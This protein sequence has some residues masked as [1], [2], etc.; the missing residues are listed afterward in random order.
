MA[1]LW[2][3]F[4]TS[5]LKYDTALGLVNNDAG[6]GPPTVFFGAGHIFSVGWIRTGG[7][8]H[9]A[10]DAGQA[11]CSGWTSDAA[12]GFGTAVGLTQLWSSTSDV[13][14]VS[15]WQA[16][17]LSCQGPQQVWCMQD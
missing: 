5:N 12:A 10:G 17:A 3:I 14:P 16:F 7:G 11:N 6:S 13:T 15:P 1:S 4:D 8:D 9:S 2:E